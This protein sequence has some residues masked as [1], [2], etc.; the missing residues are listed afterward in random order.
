MAQL[1]V[2]RISRA[3]CVVAIAAA[4][5]L[6][7]GVGDAEAVEKVHGALIIDKGAKVGVDRYK[8]PKDWERT[9]RFYRRVYGGKPNIVWRDIASTP[10]VKAVHIGSTDRERSWEGIN[11]YRTRSGVFIYV[12]AAESARG[13]GKPAG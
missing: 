7:L 2:A 5:V 12:I 9:L 11:I 6:G 13:S 4:C 3:S 8:S 1:A 10:K